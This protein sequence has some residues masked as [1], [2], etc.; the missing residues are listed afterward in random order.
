M[1]TGTG[2]AAR[3]NSSAFRKGFWERRNVR[4]GE[5]AHGGS[6]QALTAPSRVAENGP[7]RGVRK[8]VKVQNFRALM[9]WFPRVPTPVCGLV[10]GEPGSVRGRAGQPL[11][12]VRSAP[13]QHGER[14]FGPSVTWGAASGA[15]RG[16]REGPGRKTGNEAPRGTPA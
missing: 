10:K 9:S 2:R 14:G 7:R 12:T 6:G 3:P 1:T 15:G 5:T 13:G 4:G 16:M 11:G 8:V